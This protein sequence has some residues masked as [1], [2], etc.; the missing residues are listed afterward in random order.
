VELNYA[1]ASIG[2]YVAQPALEDPDSALRKADASMY[3][4]KNA[5]KQH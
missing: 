2:I 4:D 1:G 3:L 5:R